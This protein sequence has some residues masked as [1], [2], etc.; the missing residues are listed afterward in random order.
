MLI[1]LSFVGGD[2]NL[3]K[4]FAGYLQGYIYP[5]SF[6]VSPVEQIKRLRKSIENRIGGKENIKTFRR[7]N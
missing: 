4:S 2:E 3:Y 6:S 1:K 7:R 5:A